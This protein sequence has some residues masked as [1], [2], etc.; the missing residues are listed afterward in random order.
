MRIII[1][2]ST[3][4]KHI[5]E[6]FRGMGIEC[7]ELSNDSNAVKRKITNLIKLIRADAVYSVG[8][9]DVETNAFYRLANKLHKKVIIHWI[10]TDVL[11]QTNAFQS[12]GKIINSDVINLA[13][14]KQLQ[15][16]L[17][18]IGIDSLY[19]PIVPANIPYPPAPP[20]PSE[21]AVMVY[22]PTGRE[23]FYGWKQVKLLAGKNPQI[24]FYIVA[25]N[26]VKEPVS[27]NIIFMGMLAHEDLTALYKKISILL[28]IPEHDGLPVMVLE[29]QG[30][31]RKVIH[32]MKFPFVITPEN[33]SDTALMETFQRIVAEP[34]AL[35]MDAKRYIDKTFSQN[36]IAM[37]YK[38][39]GLV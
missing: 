1:S 8:G 17:K 33:R 9:F 27:D 15:E 18:D 24:P 36:C 32:N 31:G 38:E 14:S 26:G 23:K 4:T 7:I 11:I 16:E 12:T 3:Q 19:I 21:H 25:N 28:R 22:L 6:L 20:M 10:G 35:D 2:G 34:P 39:N 5:R 30:M 37:L 29:A 13:V